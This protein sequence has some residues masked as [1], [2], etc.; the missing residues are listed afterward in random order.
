MTRS[1]HAETIALLRNGAGLDFDR[2]VVRTFATADTAHR[3]AN[4]Q[5]RNVVI[6]HLDGRWKAGDRVPWRTSGRTLA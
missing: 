3:F 5:S 2:Y 4:R 1:D 6:V